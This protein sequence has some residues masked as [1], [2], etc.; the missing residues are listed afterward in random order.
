MNKKIFFWIYIRLIL[1]YINLLYS[2]WFTVKSQLA[3]FLH[4]YIDS[5]G[6]KSKDSRTGDGILKIADVE[7]I[8]LR[9]PKFHE[10]CEWGE[11]GSLTLDK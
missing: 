8:C 4:I 9:V 3:R 7:V 6:T 2:I 11:D 10:K 1:F 5:I